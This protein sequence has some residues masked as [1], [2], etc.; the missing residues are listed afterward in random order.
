MAA[1]AELIRKHEPYFDIFLLAELWM[2]KD[3]NLLQEA[4]QD[5]GLYMT[6]YRELASRYIFT[7]SY[8]VNTKMSKGSSRNDATHL[9]GRGIC[10]K[11]T[12]LH[13]SKMGD[14]GEG[15]VKNL[16]KWMTSFMDGP[17]HKNIQ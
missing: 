7:I 16:K 1:L 3:H 10:Q 4:A 6:N 5:A 15:G 17:K 12:L 8:F 11:V 14:K 13:F 9:G 2:E